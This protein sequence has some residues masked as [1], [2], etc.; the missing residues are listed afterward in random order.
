MSKRHVAILVLAVLFVLSMTAFAV[1]APT[2][3]STPGGMTTVASFRHLTGS[4]VYDPQCPP[5]AVP[6]CGGG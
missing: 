2:S 5:I 6:G 4:H 1:A 3:L